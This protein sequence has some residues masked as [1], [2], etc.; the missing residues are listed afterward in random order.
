VRSAAAGD[1]DAWEAIVA[2]YHRLIR[3][4]IRAHRLDAHEAAD[5]TQTTWLRLVQHLPSIR[6][7]E[8]LAGWLATTAHRESLRAL[9]RAGREEPCADLSC[10]ETAQQND[11]DPEA[12]ALARES[13]RLLWRCVDELPARDRLL[14][15]LLMAD[16]PLSY[17]QIS[18][19]LDMP[20]GSIGPVRARA[21]RR[22]RHI[23]QRID[24]LT[25]QPAPNSAL[26]Q[27]PTSSA[28]RVVA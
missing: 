4:V 9:R 6:E 17:R 5:V 12:V 14:L 26:R 11:A 22:L 27:Q 3:H 24:I 8:A 1:R 19:I 16:P 23:A 25:E 20:I 13:G 21:L 7:P 15:H 18:T 28:V 2:R 10:W